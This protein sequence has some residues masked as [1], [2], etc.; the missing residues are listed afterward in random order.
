MPLK[1]VVFSDFICPFCYIGLSTARRVAA[2]LDVELECRGYEIHP[3]WPAEGISARAFCAR[4]GISSSQW[5]DTWE[6]IRRLASRAGLALKPRTMMS[7]SRLALQAAEF[8][9]ER[10]AQRSFEERVF[11]AYFEQGADI[12][13]VQ[14]LAALGEE[15]GVK[16]PE[17]GAALASEQYREKL[18]D[19]A[20]TARCYGVTGVPAFLV[21]GL[22]IVGAQSEETMR[23]IFRRAQERTTSI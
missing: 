16:A 2:E 15:A 5:R 13:D 21:R 19:N 20:A 23:E 1:V 4:Q 18:A 17:L 11:R 12:G 14:V 3:A 10:D 8:A 6:H 22:P 9:R 7:N